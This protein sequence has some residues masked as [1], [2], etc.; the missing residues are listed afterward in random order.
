MALLALLAIYGS[1]SQAGEGSVKEL[2]VTGTVVKNEL[3]LKH[4]DRHR[5]SRQEVLAIAPVTVVDLLRNVPGVGVTQQGGKG[6]LTF[7][8]L[9]GGEPN[10]TVVMIDGVKV[11]DIINSR[12]GGYDFVGLDPLLIKSVD[13]Y[14]GGL[15]SVYGSEALGGVVSI[16]TLSEQYET[17]VLTLEG[18][19]DG[20]S[21]GAFHIATP[22]GEGAVANVSG[23]YRDGGHAVQ[24]D[25]LTRS[26]LNVKLNAKAGTEVDWKLNFF[27]AKG[28]SSSFPEDSGG[29]QLAVIREAEKREFEQNNLGGSMGWSLSDWWRVDVSAAHSVH[30]EV[31]DNP[32]IAAGVLAAVPAVTSDSKYRN[33]RVNVTNTLTLSEKTTLGVGA[34]WSKEKGEFDSFID[35][36]IPVPA[37]FKIERRIRAGFVELNHQ[38]SDAFSMTGGVRRDDADGIEET[39]YRLASHYHVAKTGTDVLLNYGEGFKL[40]SFFA[41]GH[42]LVGNAALQPEFSKNASVGVEQM[43]LGGQ[44]KLAATYFYNRYTDLVDFDPVLFTNVNRSKVVASG[45]ELKLTYLP[46]QQVQT[47]WYVTYTDYSAD[48]GVTLRRRPDWTGGVSLLWQP[49]DSHYLDVQANY[50]DSFFDSSRLEDT[51]IKMAGYTKVDST[52]GWRLNDGVELKFIANNLFNSGYEETVGFSNP[53]REFRIQL[54][55]AL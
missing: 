53:G 41:L 34:E 39:T 42:P 3:A 21:A 12:G 23:A 24:G 1:N 33:S 55:V 9:R 46:N 25:S 36:G 19:S 6:G 40:P 47:S 26:Q 4:V 17:Q 22:V 48:A 15:S 11:N 7:I 31:L 5:L 20:Q 38:F 29:D 18:G 28:N 51:P 37:N 54:N 50:V 2:E 14:F 52:L 49:Q 8:S 43:L 32:G 35:F 27:H 30:D 16:T 44:L 45:Q 10:F 13:V